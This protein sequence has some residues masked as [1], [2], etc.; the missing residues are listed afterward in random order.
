MKIF[1]FKFMNSVKSTI[2]LMIVLF[3]GSFLVSAQ[4]PTIIYVKKGA[5]PTGSGTSWAT[6]YADLQQG[7]A[8]ASS[9]TGPKQIWVAQG[10]YRPTETG[11]RS[12]SFQLPANTFL[13]GG[14]TGNETTLSARD[15]KKN[16][17]VL[18]AELGVLFDKSD[19]SY[20]VVVARDIG[21]NS[22]V[23][24]FII[25]EGNANN[26]G[27][28]FWGGGML[29]HA[30]TG[31]TGPIVNNCEFVN[32]SS[33]YHGGGLANVSD[34]GEISTKVTNCFFNGNKALLGGGISNWD[35]SGTNATEIFNCSF[36]ANFAF[37]DGGAIANLG[38]NA[39]VI[40]GT[41]I[42]NSS[43]ETGGAITNN[44]IN[45]EGTTPIV[46]NSIFW[47][48]F[49]GTSES[50]GNYNQIESQ[51]NAVIKDNI[52]QGGFGPAAD[53][54]LDIDPLFLRESSLQG[55]FPRTSIIPVA[56]TEPKYEKLMPFSG[57]RMP[58]S[59]VY[60]TYMDHQNNKL[61]LVGSKIQVI[62]FSTLTN[63]LPTS[64][65]HSQL[66]WGRTQRI[67]ES[68][69][70]ESN[71]IYF[72][73]KYSGLVS[74]NR[75][76]GSVA[77]ENPMTGEPTTYDNIKAQDVVIDDVNNLL[78]SPIFL[79]PGNRFY[80]LLEWNLATQAKR[81]INTT[82]TPVSMPEVVTDPD[83]PGYWGGHKL[84]LD[85]QENVL[86]YAMGNGVWWW[87]RSSNSTGVFTTEGGFPGLKPGN[88]NLPSNF[89]THMY[90]DH[91]ENKFYIGTHNGLFVWDR[92]NRTSRVYNT[93]NSKLVHNLINTVDKNEE[94]NLIY[95]ACEEGGLFI[96][97][98]LTGEERILVKDSGY[99]IN[100]QL[101]DS[102]TAS[103][104]YDEV[105]KKL[106]VSADHYNGGV[107][108]MDYNN[109]VPDFGDLRLQSGSP[110]IDRADST[111]LP[112]DITVDI[113]GSNRRTD[114]ASIQGGNSLDL[115]AYEKDFECLQP[116]V[117]FQYS[118]SSRTYTFT[119]IAQSMEACNVSYSWTFGDGIISSE[120]SPQH[121]YLSSGTYLVRMK[122]TYQCDNC[123]SSELLIEKPIT[124][125]Q[126]LCENIICHGNGGL[127]IGTSE[128]AAG[129]TLSVKGKVVMTGATV[130]LANRWPDYVFH[131][132]YKLMALPDLKKYIHENGHL[133]KVPAA[134]VI[135]KEGIDVGMMSTIILEKTEE[136][137]LH[138]IQLDERL[139]KLELRNTGDR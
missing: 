2:L 7:L 78:Y 65:I 133:P 36:T 34:G 92:T 111:A 100:P 135:E 25:T 136:L 13:Y 58:D 44:D 93:S 121:T 54:N 4:A 105:D 120:S 95:V 43:L 37:W 24:G 12:V 40:N 128:M 123:P 94:Q 86:Y 87:N 91:S 11:L 90:R 26:S 55:K 85:E 82:S 75:S 124:I 42:R 103:A 88:P 81:W 31:E 47:R 68:I 72:G 49:K 63:N 115:G 76:T 59:K 66:D 38:S 14:F 33:N 39:K 29:I 53:N 1:M 46:K 19:N 28:N 3:A 131:K 127:S 27:A 137:T 32:N 126:D 132:N 139:K 84:Y 30:T 61:Y 113:N 108:I 60:S 10:E 110:G 62:D 102:P 73:S 41:F 5:A 67:E 129:Y 9:I 57:A 70:Q 96:L 16:R 74:I 52:I 23:D 56:Y 107:L 119:P 17:T 101:V 125:S 99:E 134:N 122:V 15:W 118:Q 79:Y 69:H 51:L 106:Y 83:D 109:L 64:T 89:T 114:Y 112:A 97:N 20:H 45:A 18:T 21:S 71:K 138:L 80:G 22:G 6:A 35:L 104:H 48:N 50:E 130:A 116:S 77:S 98:T 117:D 8:A